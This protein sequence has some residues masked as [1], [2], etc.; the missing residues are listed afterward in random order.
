MTWS[1]VQGAPAAI[2]ETQAYALRQLDA[3]A[4]KL[5]SKRKL[6]DLAEAA[7]QADEQAQEWLAVLARCWQLQD[8]IAVLELDR[9]LDAAPDDLDGHRL[10]LMAARKDRLALLSRTTER[11]MARLDA[12]AARANTG[13]LRHPTKAREV[14]HAS[15]QV[16]TA[17][18][19]FHGRLGIEGGRQSLDARRWAI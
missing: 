2:A 7:E 14:V 4:D 15:N 8:A 9:V 17:V 5:E 13:V 11:L 3:L 1:K 12:A 16:G 6:S 10:G 18:L 19:E